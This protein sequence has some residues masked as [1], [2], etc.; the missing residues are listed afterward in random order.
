MRYRIELLFSYGWDAP[1][2]ETYATREEAEA[3]LVDHIE[4]L[5]DREGRGPRDDEH[6]HWSDDTGPSTYS[7]TGA[8]YEDFAAEYR[9]AEET[10]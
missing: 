4:C 6:P 8:A 7:A 10:A 2:E 9:I 1:T 5:M 3:E